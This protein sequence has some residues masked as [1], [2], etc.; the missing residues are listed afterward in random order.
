MIRRHWG[1]F[2][3]LSHG[4]QPPLPEVAASVE[5]VFAAARSRAGS[6]G[7][8]E[9]QSLCQDSLVL[10]GGGW[11]YGGGGHSDMIASQQ[12]P[13]SDKG[14]HSKRKGNWWTL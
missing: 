14:G 2:P 3:R 8:I 10:A 7:S 12:R 5:E 6:F 4:W 1:I 11:Q 13:K 9:G